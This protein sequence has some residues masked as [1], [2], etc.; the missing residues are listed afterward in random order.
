MGKIIRNEI[1]YGGSADNANSVVYDNTLSG[2]SSTNVQDAI[3][4]VDAS[5][6]SL[7]TTVSAI[8][9]S[10]YSVYAIGAAVSTTEIRIVV[11]LRKVYSS[12]PSI[13]V[14]SAAVTLIGPVTATVDTGRTNTDCAVFNLASTNLTLRQAYFCQITFSVS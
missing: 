8:T 1:I 14:S 5:V 12:T 2:L 13:I 10:T 9:N 7:S 6:D 3:D 11:P 4:E